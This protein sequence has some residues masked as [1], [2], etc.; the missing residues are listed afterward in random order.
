MKALDATRAI[1]FSHS[2]LPWG[3]GIPSFLPAVRLLDA[4][5]FPMF[6]NGAFRCFWMF[7]LGYDTVSHVATLAL[8][9]NI[10]VSLEGQV[11]AQ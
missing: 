4:F 8:P 10:N 6:V 5:S 7:L 9:K 3:K 2:A 11:R 1:F